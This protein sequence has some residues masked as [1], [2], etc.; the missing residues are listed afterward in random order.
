MQEQELG[1][2]GWARRQGACI[3][4]ETELLHIGRLQVPA[5]DDYDQ[6]LH[7]PSDAT[8]TTAL[9]TL[10]KE[11]LTLDK[12]A[13]SLLKAVHSLQEVD[14]T[15]SSAISSRM[16]IRDLKQEL[17]VLQ[18]D[19]ELDLL[20]FGSV[21]VPDFKNLQIPSEITVEQNDE[22]F[23]WP[24]KYFA[25]PA[26]CDAQVKAEKLAVTKEVLEYLQEA[27]RDAY[28]PED[29]EKIEAESTMR[30]QVGRVLGDVRLLNDAEINHPACHATVAPFVS[31]NETLHTILT[32]KSS[33]TGFGQ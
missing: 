19:H 2:L 13:A 12:E 21:A 11:R 24:A 5:N 7:D 22:G 14:A 27:T 1:I 23:T 31:A 17:P 33:T 4:Y 15:K 30:K 29:G 28:V 6:H 20:N 9:S 3:D 26:Q 25:Y 18:S 10:I 32:C 16:W 8:I